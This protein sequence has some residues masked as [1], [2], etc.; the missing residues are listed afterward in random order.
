MDPP[1]LR[2]AL[3][4]FCPPLQKD[5]CSEWTRSAGELTQAWAGLHEQRESAR[6]RARES[7]RASERE[8]GREGE[9]ERERERERVNS[10]L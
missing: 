7:E 8:R 2:R 3:S 6:A 9:R 5:L 1:N 10:C 4:M